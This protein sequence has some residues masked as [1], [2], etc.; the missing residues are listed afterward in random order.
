MKK[1]LSAFLAINIVIFCT[2]F[3]KPCKHWKKRQYDCAI[4]CGYFANPDGTPSEFMKTRVNKGVDLWKRGKVKSLI[5][6]GGAVYNEYVE[7]EVMKKYAMELGIPET[8]ILMEKQAVS[9]YHNMLHAK[10]IMADQRFRDCVVVT[11]GW[12]LRKADHYARKFKLDYVMAQ[13]EN[14]EGEPV[15]KTLWLLVKTNIHMYIN[16][17]RGYS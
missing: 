14:P 4:V 11:N 8:A 3:R 9:T 10:D 13:A 2:M 5:F 6:S 17:Y 15:L 7:A 12:H 1:L 16:M